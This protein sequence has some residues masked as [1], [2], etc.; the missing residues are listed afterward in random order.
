MRR[1]SVLIAVVALLLSATS[2]GARQIAVASGDDAYSL[3]VL[4]ATPER[5]VVQLDLNHFDLEGVEIDGDKWATLALDK[6]ALHQEAGLPALPTVRRS[7]AIPGDGI[8]GLTVTGADFVE[9]AGV[10]VAPSKGN[11]SRNVDPA[12]VRYTFD[13]FYD[14]DAWYPSKTAQLH[15]PY[16]LRD[17]RGQVLELNP[18]QYNPATHTLRVYTTLQVE[19]AWAAPGGEN[20]LA[21]RTAAPVDEFAKIYSRQFINYDAMGDRYTSIPEAGSML[22]ITYD[23]F[24]S[25]VQPFVDW[26]NQMGIATTMVNVSAVGGTGTQIKAYIQNLYDTTDL[27]FILLVGDAAQVPYY[28]NGGASDPSYTFLA[29]ADNY[30][31]ALIGRMSAETIAQVET[32]VVRSV[33]Y[34]RDAQAA[35]WYGQGIGI[36]SAQGDGIGDDGE[37]DYVHM[38][39][40]RGKLM[41][42]T[43]AGVDQIYDTNGGNATM[44]TNALNAGRSIIDYC[45]HG[46]M[47]SWGTTGFSNTNV[48]ALVN[49]NKLP[50]IH[51]V[52][53][54]VGEFQSGTCFGEAWLRATNGAEPTGA[55]GFYGSTISQSW[56]PPMSAQ[57]ETIDLLV[58]GAKRCFGALCFNGACLM[59]DEYG[60]SGETETKYWTVFGDPSLRVRTDEPTAL[61]VDHIETVDPLMAYFDVTTTPGA[62]AA[63]SYQGDY[64]GAAFADAAGLAR[65]PFTGDL[66][67]PGQEVT[68]TVSGFNHFV[69]VENVLVGDGLVPTCDVTPLAFTKVMTQDMLMTDYLHIANNGELGSTLYYNI[70]LS[71]PDYPTGGG[72]GLD[73]SIAGSTMTAD[74]PGYFPGQT[75]DVVFTANCVSNDSEW[76]K[77]VD[78]DLPAG[79]VLNSA[80]SMSG[81][82]GGDMPYNGG[83]GDGVASGWSG[84]G[85]WGSI[86]PG[87][88]AS[89]TVSL[90]FN[91]SADV[92]IPYTLTGD[93]YGSE[94]HTLN[95]EIVI[96][97]LGP[98]VNVVFPNGGEI[99][100]IGDMMPIQW[101]AGGGPAYV[102]VE[103]TRD[104]H[105]W[106]TL[107]SGLPAGFGQFAWNVDGPITAAARV[108]VT[109]ADDPGVTDTSDSA[110]TIYRTMTWVSMTST[111]GSVPEGESVSLPVIFDSTGL[112]DGTYHTNI[113]I[114]SNAGGQL[115]VP[116]TVEVLFD[117]TGVETAP[118]ALRLAQNHPNPF[119]PKTVISFALPAAGDVSLRVFDVQGRAVATLLDGVQPAGDHH[120]IWEGR[121]D[122]GQ[123]LASGVYFYRLETAGETQVKKMLLMK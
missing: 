10:D 18:F 68:L 103:L 39:V 82:S 5:S 42:F 62:L 101:T 55:V 97:L 44:V 48:N 23:A 110:F 71:D 38:D 111:G 56:A 96:S 27:A 77:Y 121:D 84:T 31:D 86:H 118:T 75:Y 8:M 67:T 16:I 40:I 17:V 92:V 33:E 36:A 66:P 122:A 7:L 1:L 88:S 30:P 14:Q 91:S 63:L 64:V 54:N 109:D 123:A 6:L 32:Q 93:I 49:D 78:F 34:E 61:A 50:F 72:I 51:S 120:V 47:T 58:T 79:V 9:F 3:R 112:P 41:G 115:V 106:E 76:I 25:A 81:G 105:S 59:N 102:N 104:G 90:T 113:A 37:A 46:S 29:G 19:V 117:P 12:M 80:T 73:R 98:A 116:A 15:T 43:Y 52:A 53:C 57:D 87:E 22:V 11:L 99:C 108:R 28:N 21:G 20:V 94:P 26:K 24:A 60:A 35:A 13:R 65:I 74:L 83:T 100:A 89:A 45:G 70:S 95:G 2:A 107:A 85:T 69:H 114:S 119:N 4:S